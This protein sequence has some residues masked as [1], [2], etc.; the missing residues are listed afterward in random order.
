ME[1]ELADEL[2]RDWYDWSRQWRPDLD[3]P[4]LAPYCR[5]AKSA[6]GWEGDSDIME[7]SFHRNTMEGD[8]F[9]REQSSAGIQSGNRAG[10]AQASWSRKGMEKRVSWR[11]LQNGCCRNTSQ[12]KGK[13]SDLTIK[14]YQLDSNRL[15]VP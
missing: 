1:I 5:E 2:L 7:E 9:L 10:N 3:M 4:H 15:I 11:Q 14:Y 8:R 12:V 13:I 6:G